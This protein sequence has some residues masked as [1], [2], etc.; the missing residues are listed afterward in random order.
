MQGEVVEKIESA[1]KMIFQLRKEVSRLRESF[2]KIKNSRSAIYQKGHRAGK[3]FG[4]KAGVKAAVKFQERL[5]AS[6]RQ[7]SL[8]EITRQEMATISHAYDKD[9][10]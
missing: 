2:T 5:E 9:Y 6:E 3:R 1:L 4:I 8:G 10:P 7:E